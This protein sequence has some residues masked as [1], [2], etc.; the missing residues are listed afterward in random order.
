MAKESYAKQNGAGIAP[1][2]PAPMSLWGVFTINEDGEK[3]AAPC[4]EHGNNL[5][6]HWLSKDCPCKP[7][8]IDG[9]WAHNDP[10]RDADLH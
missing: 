9:V 5:P 6:P 3:H 8:L 2:E 4:D 7:V 10:G 1:Q